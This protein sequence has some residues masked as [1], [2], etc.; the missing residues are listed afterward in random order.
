M[1]YTQITENNSFH[2]DVGICDNSAMYWTPDY[3]IGYS[4]YNNE[5]GVTI[6]GCSM[7]DH[8]NRPGSFQIIL[9]GLV[10]DTDA[11]EL[12]A[13]LKEKQLIPKAARDIDSSWTRQNAP[14]IQKAVAEFF[15]NK[16]RV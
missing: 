2:V 4:V 1:G 8:V 5:K 14:E 16:N 15:N 6:V 12:I 10:S 11:K 3:H 9:K 7:L 13:Y